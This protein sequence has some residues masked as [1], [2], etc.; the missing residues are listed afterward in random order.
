MDTLFDRVGRKDDPRDIASM[1]DTEWRNPSSALHK[2]I[3]QSLSLPK[4]SLVNQIVFFLEREGSVP[5]ELI[6]PEF[7][8]ADGVSQQDVDASLELMLRMNYIHLDN[9]NVQL[10]EIVKTLIDTHAN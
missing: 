9:E 5:M 1:I 8:G 6:T 3:H 10:D 4:I 7:L 2:E